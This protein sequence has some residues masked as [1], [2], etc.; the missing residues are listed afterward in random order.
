MKAAV[1]AAGKTPEEAVDARFGRAGGFIVYDLESGDWE[2][3]DNEQNLNALSGAGVQSAQNLADHGVQTVITGHVGPKA[4]SVLS[5]A[6]I[7]AFV[8]ATGTVNEAIRAYKAGE[9]NEA[10]GADVP[11]HW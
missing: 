2:Y 3:L 9:L 1:T 10:S 11:S 4:F 7:R 6:G 8:G 5:A